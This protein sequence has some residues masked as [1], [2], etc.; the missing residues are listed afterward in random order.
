MASYRVL[1]NPKSNDGLCEAEL[2]VLYHQ[3][4]GNDFKHKDITKTDDLKGYIRSLTPEEKLVICGGDGTLNHF[5]ND[6]DGIDIKNEVYFFSSGRG[7]DF[8]SSV[9]IE[10][11]NLVPLNP[12]FGKLPIVTVN[13]R[14][15]RFINGVGYGIDSYY[16]ELSDSSQGSPDNPI[17]SMIIAC[18]AFL[19]QFKPVK[20][21]IT[22]DG[23]T[24][25][26]DKVWMAPTVFG[27]F[28]SG[29]MIPVPDQNREEGAVS[30]IV[31]HHRDQWKALMNFPKIFNGELAAK[32]D[33]ATIIKG[34][35]VEVAFDRPASLM[36]DGEFF[37]N[38][39]SYTVNI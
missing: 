33:I 28:Y 2:R 36:I 17:R 11:G 18:K 23:N 20:A 6:I 5:L 10:K 8:I 25:S 12:F 3:L 35:S 38:V 7:S 13:G 26:F 32:E 1:Y 4:E 39:T 22:V 30:V 24:E 21:K 31:Y 14:E 29:G 16:R 34:R 19:F 37:R 15:Y 27:S 9:G